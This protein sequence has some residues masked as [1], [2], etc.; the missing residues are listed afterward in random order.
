MIVEDGDHD[1]LLRDYPKGTYSKLVCDQAN[2]DAQADGNE[3]ARKE[4]KKELKPQA[5][6]ATDVD[7]FEADG[8]TARGLLSEGAD[9]MKE[10]DLVAKTPDAPQVD[11]KA[12]TKE[13]E[14]ASL[15]LKEADKRLEE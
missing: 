14:Y 1:S 5:T 7:P 12:G 9:F 2:V 4:E 6:L 13:D 15:K 3:V 8:G 11:T 10:A